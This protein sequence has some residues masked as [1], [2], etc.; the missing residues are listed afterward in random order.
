MLESIRT[1]VTDKVTA[2][3]AVG[4]STAGVTWGK[5]TGDTVLQIVSYAPAV[6]G[7]VFIVARIYYMR[8]QNRRDDMRFNREF[9]ERVK[10]AKVSEDYRTEDR[11]VLGR[12]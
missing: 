8:E 7:V 3:M 6:M 5:L 12:K 2:L 9:D 4:T 10:N 1:I 11:G